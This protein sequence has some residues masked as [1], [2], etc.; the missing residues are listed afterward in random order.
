M[1]TPAILPGPEALT[2]EW[3]TSILR[4]RGVIEDAW[5]TRFSCASLGEGVGIP[6]PGASGVTG[7]WRVMPAG[8]RNR[9]L[10]SSRALS[11]NRAIGH[12]MGHSRRRDRFLR[13]AGDQVALRIHV[14][15]S[16]RNR[17]ESGFFSSRILGGYDD[18]FAA[19]AVHYQRALALNTTDSNVLINAGRFATWMRRFD[20][21]SFGHTV[22]RA[23]LASWELCLA[24]FGDDWPPT[25]I[26]AGKRLGRDPNH[27]D[28]H[29]SR[30]ARFSTGL[31]PRQPF[32]GNVPGGAPVGGGLAN[33]K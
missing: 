3:L 8:H 13:Q 31:P 21:A 32:F 24:H 5:V 16:S 17:V 30:R 27:D 14:R 19:A 25:V 6:G 10:R 4:A 23:Y 26:E 22:Q 12:G 33:L 9:S 11:P 7:L 28:A 20:L 2:V 29:C 1:P 18:D 15:I